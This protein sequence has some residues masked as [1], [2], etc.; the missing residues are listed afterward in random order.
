[1]AQ[2]DAELTRHH[3]RHEFHSYDG[4]GHAFQDFT[5]KTQY[6]EA[7]SNDAWSKLLAFLRQELW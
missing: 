4:T 2:L 7:A 3:I 1:M 6:R 5:S